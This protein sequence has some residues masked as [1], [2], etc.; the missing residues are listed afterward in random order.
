MTVVDQWAVLV[1][2]LGAGGL[3]GTGSQ[4]TETMEGQASVDA[5][6]SN[7]TVLEQADLPGSGALAMPVA[8]CAESGVLPV[9]TPVSGGSGSTGS[10]STGSV[11]SGAVGSSPATTVPASSA[12]KHTGG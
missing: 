8:A 12:A 9:G 3:G 7:G 6:S 4:G 2:Q 1:Q 10:G 5:L 11:G